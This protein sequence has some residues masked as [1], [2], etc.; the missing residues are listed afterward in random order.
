MKLQYHHGQMLI[1]EY[2][3]VFSKNKKIHPQGSSK[4]HLKTIHQ[5]LCSYL[6]QWLNEWTVSWLCSFL[7]RRREWIVPPSRV[8]N[9]QSW[10]VGQLQEMWGLIMGYYC[11]LYCTIFLYLFRRQGKVNHCRIRSKQDRG[12]TK[13]FLID[14]NCF[15][16]LYSLI[17]HYRSHPLRSQVGTVMTVCCL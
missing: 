4:V 10:T 17:T 3:S 11:N 16:S 12:Q 2:C 7:I 9:F 15:D 1:P 6:N 5:S 8:L 14:S 13:Y